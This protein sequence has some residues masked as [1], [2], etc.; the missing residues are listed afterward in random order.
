M[1]KGPCVIADMLPTWICVQVEWIDMVS[2][3]RQTLRVC[4]NRYKL[5]EPKT[6]TDWTTLRPGLQLRFKIKPSVV[7]TV[8]K[9]V[10]GPIDKKEYWIVKTSTNQLTT[11]VIA[12]SLREDYEPL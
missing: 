10:I 5:H 4:M 3:Q 12:E 11:T 9:Q 1:M 7:V 6:P 8:V 2:C